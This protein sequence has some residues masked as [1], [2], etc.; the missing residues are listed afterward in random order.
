MEV[1]DFELQKARDATR[2]DLV[3]GRYKTKRKQRVLSILSRFFV[4][5]S[6]KQSHL[7]KNNNSSQQY[8]DKLN[9]TSWK[10]TVNIRFYLY[11]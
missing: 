2:S 3:T 9:L 1:H 10:N 11:R 7:K 4:R 6:I 5:C 8:A